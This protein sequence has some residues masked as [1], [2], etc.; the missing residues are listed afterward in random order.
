L[1]EELDEVVDKINNRPRKVLDFRTPNEVYYA[2]LKQSKLKKQDCQEYLPV[3][4]AS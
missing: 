2:E 1:K 4:I 3:T